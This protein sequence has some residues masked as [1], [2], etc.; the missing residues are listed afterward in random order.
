MPRVYG[1]RLEVTAKHEP[2]DGWAEL[3]TA[4]DGTPRRLP[5]EEENTDGQ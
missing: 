4:I 3:L 2:G 1:D 5:S